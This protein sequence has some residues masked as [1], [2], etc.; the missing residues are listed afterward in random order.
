MVCETRQKEV[1]SNL[2]CS[3]DDRVAGRIHPN[4]KARTFQVRRWSLRLVGR[5]SPD[6]HSRWGCI[7]VWV[8]GVVLELAIQV[9]R[10]YGFVNENAVARIA[11]GHI[12]ANPYQDT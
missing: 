1:L 2:A 10:V 12:F 6:P 3:G 11:T 9:C 5:F 4:R 7:L 8:A